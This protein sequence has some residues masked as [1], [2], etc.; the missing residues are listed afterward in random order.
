MDAN[1]SNSGGVFVH[2]CTCTSVCTS[3]HMLI[4]ICLTFPLWQEMNLPALKAVRH[5][6]NKSQRYEKTTSGVGCRCGSQEHD[7]H[8]TT[9]RRTTQKGGGWLQVFPRM[10]WRGKR[11][12]S[13]LQC[14]IVAHI[15]VLVQQSKAASRI[16]QENVV[17]RV[18]AN[19]DGLIS[20]NS[21]PKRWAP[22]TC[23]RSKHIAPPTGQKDLSAAQGRWEPWV[24]GL[25]GYSNRKLFSQYICLHFDWPRS[26]PHSQPRVWVQHPPLPFSRQAW[27]CPQNRF[28]S[29]FMLDSCQRFAQQVTNKAACAT[30]ANDTECAHA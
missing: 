2:A 30:G 4:Y 8:C 3:V 23:P 10:G 12:R 28:R 5:I 26:G 24:D 21:L 22:R 6:L 11:T 14:Y 17:C 27:C 20:V 9:D 1:D 29:R 13:H 18:H 7:L 25:S 16:K 15:R 19:T